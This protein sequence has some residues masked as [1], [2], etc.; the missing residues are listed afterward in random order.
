MEQTA[1]PYCEPAPSDV[2][3]ML[4]IA[5]VFATGTWLFRRWQKKRGSP[6]NTGAR[7]ISDCYD[8][9]WIK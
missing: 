1:I 3:P 8:S 9:S 5:A 2:L 7:A 6:S 4:V